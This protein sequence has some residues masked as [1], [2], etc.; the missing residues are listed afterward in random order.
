MWDC[1]TSYKYGDISDHPSEVLETVSVSQQWIVEDGQATV[2][3]ATLHSQGPAKAA[4]AVQ[5]GQDRIALQLDKSV[6]E[7][8]SADGT[9]V[10]TFMNRLPSMPVM[11]SRPCRDVKLGLS[12]MWMKA[13]KCPP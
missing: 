3:Q 12:I 6:R 4:K 2:E 11:P 10:P 9:A 13:V 5:I 7:P 8:T 1:H